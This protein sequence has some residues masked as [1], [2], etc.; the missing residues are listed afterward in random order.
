MKVLCSI[1]C[2]DYKDYSLQK[3]ID[4]AS[5]HAIASRFYCV[6]KGT[7]RGVIGINQATCKAGPNFPM[8]PTL[9]NVVWMGDSISIGAFP[10]FARALSDVALVQHA[11]WG[12]NGGAE[13]TAYGDACLHHFLHSP[14]GFP[15]NPD[16]IIFNF[17]MHDVS[18]G[19]LCVCVCVFARDGA[20]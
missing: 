12:G 13:E 2:C 17:G 10:A 11:P 4:L 3:C 8:H 19:G 6:E 16:L 18:A 15:I 20:L 9:R 7:D 1:I 14:S 5:G